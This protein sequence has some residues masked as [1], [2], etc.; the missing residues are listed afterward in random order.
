[1][2]APQASVSGSRR[3][4]PGTQPE[5][6]PPPYRSSVKRARAEALVPL[7]HGLTEV[8]GPSFESEVREIRACD[9]TRQHAQPPL[10]E[11]IVVAGRVLDEDGKALPRT[12][13]EVWQAN[14]AGRYLHAVDQHDAPLDPNFSGAGRILTDDEGRYRVATIPPRPDPRGNTH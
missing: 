7:P 5:Y 4:R 10:G 14:A 13:V 6:L 9:L 11:R 12:L 8:T 3:P 1:P 2:D